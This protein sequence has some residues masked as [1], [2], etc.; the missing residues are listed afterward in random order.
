[1][2][3][4]EAPLN[5]RAD[6]LADADKSMGSGGSSLEFQLPPTGTGREG[7]SFHRL[8]FRHNCDSLW[9]KVLVGLVERFVYVPGFGRNET[10]LVSNLDT[11]EF[12]V[13]L[14]RRRYKEGENFSRKDTYVEC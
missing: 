14:G 3:F 11:P 13:Y 2:A 9:L 4:I 10:G 6:I 12:S 1:V 8:C 5:L 7:G